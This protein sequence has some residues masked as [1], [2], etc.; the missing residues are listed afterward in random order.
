MR[1]LVVPILTLALARPHIRKLLE[2]NRKR[3][4]QQGWIK[5]LMQ[6]G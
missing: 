5:A 3:A 4:H 6:E 2:R 1:R